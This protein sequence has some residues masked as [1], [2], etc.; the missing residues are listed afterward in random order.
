MDLLSIWTGAWVGRAGI[1]AELCS[2]PLLAPEILG[3]ERLRGANKALKE[4]L[5]HREIPWWVG[6]GL[7]GPVF[8]APLAITLLGLTYWHFPM[9]VFLYI[10]CL[11]LSAAFMGGYLY[12][13]AS[14]GP[15]IGFEFQFVGPYPPPPPPPP[16]SLLKRF[17]DWS[18]VALVMPVVVPWAGMMTLW[19]FVNLPIEVAGFLVRSPKAFRGLIF[20]TGVLFLLGG[21]IAQFI[22]TF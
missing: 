11:A 17:R 6:Y 10:I 12:I 22:A 3:E 9:P 7:A 1:L 20:G 19:M 4:W 14:G 2:F 21:V 8:A 15:I 5:T 13:L 18:V 16:P